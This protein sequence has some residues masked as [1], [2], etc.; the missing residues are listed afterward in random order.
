MKKLVS[1]LIAAVVIVGGVAHAA[2]IDS[3]A[4]LST[5]ALLPTEVSI[6]SNAFTIRLW[7]TGNLPSAQSATVTTVYNMATDGTITA[8]ATTAQV[9]FASQNYG[10]GTNQA[11]AGDTPP[12]GCKDNPHVV[13]ATL[14]VASG[15]ANGTTG[16]LTVQ[17]TGA[18]GLS[19]DLTPAQGQVKVVTQSFVFDGFYRP[20]DEVNTVKAGQGVALKWNLLDGSAKVEDEAAK[21]SL[22]SKPLSPCTLTGG[23]NSEPLANDAGTSAIRWD[24]SEKQYVFVW[25]TNKSWASS[26]RTLEL[27]YDGQLIGSADFR[28][29]R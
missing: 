6:G 11:C 13:N 12:A 28:F 10:D 2:E 26:C 17:M 15:T 4:S 27:S 8:G 3:S 18:T 23:D 9:A 24:D 1:A 19:A 5:N 14:N 7:A 20:V 22:S 29:T 16:V 25:K 21:F